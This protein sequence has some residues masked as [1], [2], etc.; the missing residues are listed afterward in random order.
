ML[1]HKNI[2]KIWETEID[3]FDILNGDHPLQKGVFF[4]GSS[5]IRFW[6]DPAFIDI[7]SSMIEYLGNLRK[8]DYVRRFEDD[9]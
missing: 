1:L 4:S 5:S 9:R 8:K 2:K 7:F 6:Q 3:A